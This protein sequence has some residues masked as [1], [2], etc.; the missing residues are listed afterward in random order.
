MIDILK[1]DIGQG[2][3]IGLNRV[4]IGQ[5]RGTDIGH[6]LRTDQGQVNTGRG[7]GQRSGGN[8][9]NIHTVKID[10]PVHDKT[11]KMKC[12]SCKDAY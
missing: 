3:A 4:S 11:K 1:T 8:I 12:T 2:H 9:R 7:Q 6:D 10:E 5:G